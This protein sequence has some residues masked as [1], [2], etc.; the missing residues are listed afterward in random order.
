MMAQVSEDAKTERLA[1]LLELLSQQQLAFNQA[2]V[3]RVLPILVTGDG[4]RPG[5]KQGRSPYLQGVHFDDA[6]AAKG[7]TVAVRV[8]AATQG[9]LSGVRHE[10]ATA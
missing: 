6:T 8:T 5:Q 7:E 3:G 9:S 10:M 2:Q 1:R 4:R